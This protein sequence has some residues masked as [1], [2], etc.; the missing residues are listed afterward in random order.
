MTV[1]NM[2]R[3]INILGF[4]E[5]MIKL[6]NWQPNYKGMLCVFEKTRHLKLISRIE[7]YNTNVAA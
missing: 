5:L 7:F 6:K 3:S 4:E 1:Y 2:R